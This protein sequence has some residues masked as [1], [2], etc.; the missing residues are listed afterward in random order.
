MQSNSLT[1]LS[2]NLRKLAKLASTEQD[3]QPKQTKTAYQKL[4]SRHVLNFIKF[5]GGRS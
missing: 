4:D 1:Q 3:K 2:T 5:F